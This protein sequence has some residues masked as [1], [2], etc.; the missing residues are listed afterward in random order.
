MRLVGN[1]FGM[2]L[3]RYAGHQVRSFGRVG[4]LRAPRLPS[5][6]GSPSIALFASEEDKELV[7]E[8]GVINWYPGHIAKA[9]RQLRGYLKRVDVVI[10][11]RDARIAETTAHPSVD[12]WVGVRPHV[13]VYTFSDATPPAAL[14]EWKESAANSSTPTFFV[15]AK[16]GGREELRGLREALRKAGRSVNAKRS[17]KGIRPRAARVAVI[18]FPNVGKSA[19]IN[20]L[21]GRRA[22]KSENRAGVTRSLN[23][24]STN[25]KKLAANG[26]RREA[27]A[28]DFE[29]LDSPGIIPAKQLDSRSAAR[30]AMCG[31]IGG[32]AYDEVLVARAFLSELGKVPRHYLPK[33]LRETM[34]AKLGVDPVGLSPDG[35]IQSS[36]D[37]R[38]NGD[39]S[40]T[41]SVLLAEFRNG[42]LGKIALEQPPKWRPQRQRA[43]E[44]TAAAAAPAA[45]LAFAL[46]GTDAVDVDDLRRH[47]AASDFDGW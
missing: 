13:V 20:K 9:E 31:D 34:R 28:D 27:T 4:A 15:D 24:V 40:I 33:T 2:R 10:E 43:D 22:A 36:A 1:A 16:R 30:L 23:W 38:Y 45:P 3:A 7:S 11:T 21:A 18:G 46:D 17:L 8:A 25:Q 6:L 14:R 32:A 41:A 29:L 26:E 39:T 35:F 12:E 19:L 37:E 5:T 42:R 47:V 44:Q